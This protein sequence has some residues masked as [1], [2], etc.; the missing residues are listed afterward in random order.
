MQYYDGDTL[1]LHA[2]TLYTMPD[3]NANDAK[4]LIAYNN[5]RFFRTD[6]QGICD[7]LIYFTKDSTIQMYNDPVLWSNENQMNAEYIEFFN[8][9]QPPNEVHLKNNAFIIQEVD[10]SKYNQIKG[11]SMVGF[12]NGQNLYRIDVNGNGQSIYYPSDQD[13]YIGINKAESSNII[14]YLSENQIN[15]ITFVGSPTGVMNPLLDV[16]PADTK[17]DGYRWR[18]E[19]RPKSK[20]EI[21]GPSATTKPTT[22]LPSS[23]IYLP[24]PDIEKSKKELDEQWDNPALRN[25]EE[26]IL[27]EIINEVNEK[28]ED[29]FIQMQEIEE[30]DSPKNE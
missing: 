30:K 13:D 11:K 25:I 8:R 21:F 9:S 23:E 26:P 5:N 1:F 28:I 4:M 20:F 29:G 19:E 10:S 27:E 16:V 3:K 24:L 15:R 7:S 14:I 2:D 22:E 18:V 12:I 6:I 17:L